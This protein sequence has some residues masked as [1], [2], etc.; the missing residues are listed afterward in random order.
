MRLAV[1]VRHG[2]LSRWV[3]LL[4]LLHHRGFSPRRQTPAPKSLPH[5]FKTNGRKG[6]QI[7]STRTR[8][9]TRG[10]QKKSS[11]LPGSGVR[12]VWLQKF[13]TF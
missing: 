7:G 1:P 10:P 8:T 12:V 2:G 5:W 13:A 6:V 3:L 4:P 11:R 9:H